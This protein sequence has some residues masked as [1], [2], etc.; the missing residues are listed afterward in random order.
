VPFF[1]L[2]DIFG[3][4]PLPKLLSYFWASYD[5]NINTTC[6]LT[7]LYMCWAR[8]RSVAVPT[9]FK[10]EILIKNPKTVMASIWV[11]GLSIWTPITIRYNNLDFSSNLNYDPVY[12]QN[13]FN[14]LF[15][16]VPLMLILYFSLQIIWILKKRDLKKIQMRNKVRAGLTIATVFAKGSLIQNEPMANL[17]AEIKKQHVVSRKKPSTRWT[18]QV[19][20]I[21]IIL[22]YWIQWFIP[23]VAVL[24]NGLCNC[25]PN[26]F[27]VPI[28]WLT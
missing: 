18:P 7:M 13:I 26:R 25:I 19:R 3:Y 4:W 15:W 28:Y 9:T 8:Y 21:L 11:I 12:L 10:N 23:C 6:N 22:I 20:F 16:F 14:T 17:A 2:Q 27:Y 5:N 24:V 1:H